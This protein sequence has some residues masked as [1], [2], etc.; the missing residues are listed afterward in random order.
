MSLQAYQTAAT[1]AES[2]RETEYRLFGF[3][4]GELIRVQSAGRGDLHKFVEAIDR[5]RRMWSAFSTDCATDGNGLPNDLRAQIVSIAGWVS[6]YSSEV[7]RDGADIDP[8]ID[9]N[10]NVMQGLAPAAAGN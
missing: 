1:R 10:K 4:T 7:I 2:P 5:N 8:L 3:V 6:R 9:V